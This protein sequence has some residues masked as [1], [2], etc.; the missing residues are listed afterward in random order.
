MSAN[1]TQV[2]GTHYTGKEFQPWD[3][4]KYGIGT[5]EMDILH[6]VT[7]QK[8]GKQDLEKSC[9]YVVKLIEQYHQFYRRN[10]VPAAFH[11]EVVRAYAAY[12][13]EW[14]MVTQQRRIVH[15]LLFWQTDADLVV[16]GHE[17][18]AYIKHAYPDANVCAP[19]SGDST[20]AKRLAAFQRGVNNSG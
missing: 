13:A 7:R 17:L 2:G 18:K 14:N 12:V 1:D 8:G 15:G 9:H 3:W 20:E 6:Y 11:Q 19:D 10:R 5:Y 4:D 16:I